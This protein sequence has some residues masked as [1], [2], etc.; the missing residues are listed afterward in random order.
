MPTAFFRFSGSFVSPL[1]GAQGIAAGSPFSGSFS[2]D[3][4]APATST[5]PVWAMYQSKSFSL[6]FPNGTLSANQLS[7]R[8][9]TDPQDPS[10][11]IYGELP[12]NLFMGVLLRGP[13]GVI[14]STGLPAHITLSQFLIKHFTLSDNKGPLFGFDQTPTP[15]PGA[16]VFLRGELTSLARKLWWWPW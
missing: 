4:S 9:S 16:K 5:G 8:I 7:V 3:L 10:I 13:T 1:V 12:F 14:A 2:Y 11:Q 15:P 6:A